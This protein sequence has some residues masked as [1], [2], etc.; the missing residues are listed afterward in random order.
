MPNVYSP[1][2]APTWAAPTPILQRQ[3]PVPRPISYRFAAGP[4]D[5]ALDSAGRVQHTTAAEAAVQWAA[6]AMTTQRAAYPIYDPNF[7]VDL[8]GALR[9]P[10]RQAVQR[11]LQDGMRA[12]IRP[13]R[14]SRIRDAIDFVFGWGPQDQLRVAW[15][16]VLADGTNRRGS[17]TL[18]TV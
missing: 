11:A 14:D 10:T 2:F 15:T 18:A 7:G 3:V 1:G 6:K 9:Q 13:P 4:D 17:V 8:E 16:L 12:A 5:F